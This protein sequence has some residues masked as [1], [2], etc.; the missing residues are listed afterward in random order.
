MDSCHCFLDGGYFEVG[1]GG[2]IDATLGYIKTY[3]QNQKNIGRVLD[4]AVWFWYDLMFTIQQTHRRVYVE[5]AQKR[6]GT[7]PRA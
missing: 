5:N 3:D 1:R 6:R 7:D 2:E 4:R